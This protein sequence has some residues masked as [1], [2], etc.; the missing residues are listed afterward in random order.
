MHVSIIEQWRTQGRGARGTRRS[1]QVILDSVVELTLFGTNI[2]ICFIFFCIAFFRIKHCIFPTKFFS[3]HQTCVP[4][5]SNNFL[6]LPLLLA[7]KYSV[8]AC[9][10]G[11]ARA[12]ACTISI[13]TLFRLYTTAIFVKLRSRLLEGVSF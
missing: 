5:T 8:C 6:D 2:K 3:C 7:L 10:R 11:R 1:P 4:T 9:V 12:Y 13:F